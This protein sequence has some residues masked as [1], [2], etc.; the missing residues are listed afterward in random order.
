MDY[1]SV[2]RNERCRPEVR[3]TPRAIEVGTFKDIVVRARCGGE[4]RVEVTTV[5]KTN[6]MASFA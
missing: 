3:L 5:S 4:I 6:R 2:G 1:E